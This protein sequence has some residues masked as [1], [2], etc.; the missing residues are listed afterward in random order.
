MWAYT[1]AGDGVARLTPRQLPRPRPGPHQLLVRMRAASLNY[2]DLLVINGVEHWRP[3]CDIVPVSDGVGTVVATGEDTTRFDVG[4]RVSAMFLPH[5]HSGPLTRDNNGPAVGGPDRAGVLAEYIVVDEEAAA[6]PPAR[7]SDAEAACLPI[8]ALTAWHALVVRN[9]VARGDT[10]L[11]HG[12]G[13]VA[14]FALQFAVAL[15]A[16]VAIT[17]S[18]DAKLARAASLGA[19]LGVNYRT[20]P[21]IVPPVLRWTS[22]D[23]VDHVIETVGGENL[24]ASLR[25]VRIGGT[26]AFIGLIAGLTASV[27][28]YEFVGKNV[29]I[30]GV[31]TGSR[32]MYKAMATFIDNN[33][34][35]PVIEETYNL[36]CL[37]SAFARLQQG[38]FG[39]IVV[40]FP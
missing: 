31:E 13:G 32:E 8:A 19:E 12:S 21:D 28:V 29:S 5:W 38:A 34:V 36:Q 26:I 20:D 11:I 14:L 30:F 24:N 39:K 7:L 1:T 37:P 35:R 27:N 3:S 4:A 16:R 23:G 25:S 9:Q 15:G 17:S 33:G 18:S 2:R 10:V 40:T 22:G 6:T